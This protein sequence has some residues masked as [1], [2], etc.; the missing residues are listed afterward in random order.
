MLFRSALG[1]V[2]GAVAGLV[3]VTPAAGWV[4]PMGAI[5]IG[6]AAGVICFW[7]VTWLKAIFKYDDSLDVFG[8]HGVGGIVGAILT[9]VFVN[10]ALGG[11]GVTNYAATA[12][13]TTMVPYEFGAQVTA[14]L[15]GVA[16]SV[17]LSAVVSLVALI[18]IKAIFGI[19][20]SEQAEREGLD[21]ATH[22]ERAY[23]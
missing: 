23:N 22:G 20:V 15:W 21:I 10:P 2:S 6:A 9:G 17:V 13:T 14:Q 18:I 1:A 11:T 5:A 3:A 12:A 16:T 7:A 8:V 4:G 19:R